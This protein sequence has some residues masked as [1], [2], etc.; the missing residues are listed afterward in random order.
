MFQ[1]ITLPALL[2]VVLIT[3]AAIRRRRLNSRAGAAWL[4]LWV[5]AA[6]SVAFPDIL[7]VV[8]RFLGI[9]RGA[10][11]ILYFSILFMFAGFFLVYLRFRRI[12]DQ[13]TRIVR[14]LA[15][16]DGEEKRGGKAAP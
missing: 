13:L 4:L 15:I 8:A 3:A 6:V 16:R 7:V 10:D 2:V 14:H 12:D 5:A 11:L 1:W 9:G